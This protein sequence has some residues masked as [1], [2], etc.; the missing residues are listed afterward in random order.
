[1][2]FRPDCLGKLKDFYPCPDPLKEKIRVLGKEK[3]FGKTCII[4]G[5]RKELIYIAADMLSTVM[6]RE[7]KSIAFKMFSA[8]DLTDLWV[9]NKGDDDW[10]FPLPEHTLKTPRFII[11]HWKFGTSNKELPNVVLDYLT[12]RQDVDRLWTYFFTEVDFP[13][14]QEYVEDA[15]DPLVTLHY[16]SDQKKELEDK[17][18]KKHRRDKELT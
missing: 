7:N 12:A 16:F 1:M 5:K 17:D 6:R 10:K 14:M 3:R 9:G 8:R 2:Q 4:V 15:D 11:T 18:R 13:I